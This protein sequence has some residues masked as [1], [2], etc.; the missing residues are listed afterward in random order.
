MKSLVLALV[1]MVS[2][3]ANAGIF[4]SLAKKMEGNWL[5]L[6]AIYVLDFDNESEEGGWVEAQAEDRM[7][8]KKISRRKIQFEMESWHTNGHSC[9]VDGIA[10]KKG[11][12]FVFIGEKSF[13]GETCKLE[14][15][16]NKEGQLELKDENNACK[17][18]Y[19]GMRGY[20]D[21]ATFP[22]QE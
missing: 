21:G 10:T 17:F 22:I 13:D 2:A 12:K 16:V 15:F 3:S 4:T 19:C 5:N 1:L 20:L 11:K 18:N 14:I 8:I 7:T 9:G 6:H